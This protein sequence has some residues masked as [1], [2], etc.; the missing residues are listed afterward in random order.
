MK[1]AMILV[2][3]ALLL[4][5]C[6]GDSGST[7]NPSDSPPKSAE[8]NNLPPATSASNQGGQG[9]SATAGESG[10]AVSD[11][12][13]GE[14]SEDNSTADD[15][16]GDRRET[17]ESVAASPPPR[18]SENKSPPAPGEDSDDDI[19]SGESGESEAPLVAAFPRSGLET[20]FS[21][22]QLIPEIIGKDTEGADFRLSDYKEKVIMLDFWG[23]W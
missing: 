22:G 20:G 12:S 13:A 16:T 10:D 4:C 5:S 1:R 2:L 19:A 7:P 17:D 23:D 6:S 8:G 9:E 15:E 21:E 3:Y 14:V 18:E 11:N